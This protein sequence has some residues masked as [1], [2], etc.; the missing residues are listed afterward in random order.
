VRKDFSEVRGHLEEIGTSLP[1]ADIQIAAT[2]IY[3]GLALVTGNVRH[4]QRIKKIRLNTVL[5]DPR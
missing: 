5:S 1:D 2:A 3:H 4:F